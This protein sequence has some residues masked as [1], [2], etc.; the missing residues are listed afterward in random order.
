MLTLLKPNAQ[1][2]KW[3]G[4]S[5]FRE[6]LN[7]K[8][9]LGEADQLLADTFGEDVIGL[10]DPKQE[11]ARLPV[12]TKEESASVILWSRGI[13]GHK[14]ASKFATYVDKR[15]PAENRASLEVKASSF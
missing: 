12:L 3:N 7:E 6:L 14:S 11:V 13:Y 8:D 15:L 4:F 2:R 1:Q 10:W 9:S 5:A